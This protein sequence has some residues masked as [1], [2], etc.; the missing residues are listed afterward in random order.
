MSIIVALDFDSQEKVDTLLNKLPKGVFVKVGMELFYGLGPDS[1]FRLKEKGHKVF[2]DLK[3]HDI[4]NTVAKA[5][6]SLERLE[7][8]MVTLHTLGGR[9]MLREA[10]KEIKSWKNPPLLLGVTQLTSINDEIM[11]NEMGIPGRVV[12][13]AIRK[14][15]LAY[16]NGILGVIASATDCPNIKSRNNEII[17]VC[18]GI[19]P[20]G[21][22]THDQKRIAT[23]NEAKR[24]GADYIV[25][26]RP[27][28]ES[29][30]PGKAYMDIL[31]EWEG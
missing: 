25:V 27:I 6:R 18:P 22:S 15:I 1:I 2:L 26:G 13:D 16:G 4:P 5:L 10:S 11:N 19:R 7:P 28:T 17:V 30:D 29:Q 3:L 31:R 21:S 12:D 23:P 9:E 24:L 20:I 8:D 14:A